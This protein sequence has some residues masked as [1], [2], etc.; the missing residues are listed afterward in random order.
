LTRPRS[1]AKPPAREA[2]HLKILLIR[3]RLIG[4]VVLTTPIVRAL[5]RAHSTAALTYLV[6]PHAA[7]VV[8][9][10]PHLD[11]V[12]VAPLLGGAA[13]W[14]ADAALGLRL[15]REHFD[16]VIDFHGGPRSSWLTL[17]TG[18]PARI[19]YA[20]P[21]RGWMY[22]RQVARP[23]GH[24]ERHSVLNQ[25]DLLAAA[26]PGMP[27]PTPATDPVEMA[28]HPASR[29]RVD[30]KLRAWGIEPDADL[31]VM[32]VGAGNEFRRWPEASFAEVVAVLTTGRPKRRIILTTGAAQAERAD[33]VRQMAVALG[34]RGDQVMVA[35]DIDLADLRSLAG[36]SALFVGGD[37]G[38]AHVVSTTPT[39]MV[40]IFGPTTDAVWG[41]WR[42]PA[43]V[44]EIVHA[45][46]LPCRPCDQRA[47]EPGDFRCLRRIG[48]SAVV[49]AAERA[50][51]RELARRT[52][53][54]IV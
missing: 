31:V 8:E 21:G 5:R 44:T 37:S 7:P 45:G 41:P 35:C 2:A 36:R 25:W 34:T 50:M 11:H 27:N 51:D 1:R 40:V 3:L 14:R 53:N 15:R 6:E 20:V 13:R 4:D 10:N 52:S 18:A 33:A 17:A 42:D 39:P 22:T 16:L 30:A 32:H 28:E 48:A 23:R 24:R 26:M 54:R 46:S 29:A 19:G 43:L 9:T 49:A 12:I 38:P 47:C